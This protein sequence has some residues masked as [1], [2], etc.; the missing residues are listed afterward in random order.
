MIVEKGANRRLC[1]TL[2]GDPLGAEPRAEVLDGSDVLMDGALGMATFFKVSGER[3]NPSTEGVRPQTGD[4][5]WSS[6]KVVQ[7][8][9]PSFRVKGPSGGCRIM[10]TNTNPE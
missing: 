8:G 7:H 3:F 5:A 1:H 2:D 6:E 10:Q 4:N 9:M